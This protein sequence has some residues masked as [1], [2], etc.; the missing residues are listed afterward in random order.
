MTAP[1][2]EA[3]AKIRQAIDRENPS[4]VV[5][6]E[7]AAGTVLFAVAVAFSVF[8]IWTAAFNPLSSMVVR[9]VHVGFLM[10]MTFVLFGIRQD[11]ER[12]G[13]PWYDWLLG[14]TGFAVGLYH[15]VFETELILRAGDPSTADLVVGAIAVALVFEAARRIMGLVLPI[16]CGIF[17]PYALFGRHLPFGLA[18]RGYDLDQVIDNLYLSVEGIYGTPTFVSATFIFLFILFGA[19]LERAGMIKLFNDVSLGLVGHAKGGPAKV[20]V[21]SSGFMGTINGSGVATC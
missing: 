12:R 6:F 7:G 10:L 8:Q 16:L 21:I 1:S 18:H 15:Y 13:V 9:S 4:T 19:F 3:D 17:I 14:L 2:H 5:A 20:A 11:R